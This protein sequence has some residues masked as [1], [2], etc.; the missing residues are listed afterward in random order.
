M[1]HRARELS[2]TVLGLLAFVEVGEHAEGTKDDLLVVLVERQLDTRF[3][4]ISQHQGAIGAEIESPED[5]GHAHGRGDGVGLWSHG[6][7]RVDERELRRVAEIEETRRLAGRKPERVH[8]P[9][10]FA[11]SIAPQDGRSAADRRIDDDLQE[12]P[13]DLFLRTAFVD[14][15]VGLADQLGDGTRAPRFAPRHAL[16]LLEPEH[17]IAQVVRLTAVKVAFLLQFEQRMGFGFPVHAASA[18]HSTVST[19]VQSSGRLRPIS[20]AISTPE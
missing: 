19:P 9:Q 1:L 3:R 20:G 5:E 8:D 12:P 13:A 14:D 17:T 6:R 18:R 10:R 7:G 2:Q 15:A 4:L 11:V 16:L